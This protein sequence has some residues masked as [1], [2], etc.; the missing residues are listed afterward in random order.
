MIASS[1][2]RNWK[3]VGKASERED[4]KKALDDYYE[5]AD[6]VAKSQNTAMEAIEALGE[7]LDNHD[8]I[9]NIL[10]HVQN[11]CI[12][13]TATQE[14]LAYTPCYPKGEEASVP[15]SNYIGAMERTGN[16]AQR[17]HGEAV[18][19]NASRHNPKRDP[20]RNE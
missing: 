20:N 1:S 18:A 9:V 10:K 2:E 8:T 7:A 15:L 5:E 16:E 6:V 17:L 11:P 12:Q 14:K 19:S 4:V 3:R 13:V